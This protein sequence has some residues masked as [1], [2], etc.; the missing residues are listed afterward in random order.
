MTRTLHFERDRDISKVSGPG[1][2]ALAVEW[3]DGSYSTWWYPAVSGR[4]GSHGWQPDAGELLRVH[5]HQGAT[6][7]VYDDTGEELAHATSSMLDPPEDSG[8][9]KQGWDFPKDLLE[10]AWGLI[11]SANHGDWYDAAP[12]WREAAQRW[13]DAYHETLDAE[14]SADPEIG[15]VELVSDGYVGPLTDEQRGRIDAL[16]AAREVLAAKGFASSGAVDAT[17]LV[18][19]ANWIMDGRPEEPPEPPF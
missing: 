5:G 15:T 18:A 10:A 8:A 12:G 7:F 4:Q 17:S 9:I 16:H 13:R 11:A 1:R 19:V 14:S 2:V 6:R 3:P